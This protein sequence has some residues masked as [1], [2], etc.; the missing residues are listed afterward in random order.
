[1]TEFAANDALFPRYLLA[2]NVM[3]ERT[4][5]KLW[6]RWYDD[7]H[8]PQIAACPGFATAARYVTEEEPRQYLTLY[9]LRDP[10]AIL[11]PEFRDR[12]GWGASSKT[13]SRRRYA[14]TPAA[15]FC[16][17]GLTHRDRYGEPLGKQNRP[18]QLALDPDCRAPGGLLSQTTHLH[19]DRV[20]SSARPSRVL[21]GAPS[22]AGP[23]AARSGPWASGKLG[24]ESK[25]SAPRA[26]STM[27][28]VPSIWR[29]PSD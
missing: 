6:N 25:G 24:I 16:P 9:G 7:V 8:L 11:T 2:V 1:M 12:R 27:V 10:G 20:S 13:S 19:W 28:Q 4:A 3:V 23:T 26:N 29:S 21:M 18:K 17:R 15:L 5:E 22:R 14:C